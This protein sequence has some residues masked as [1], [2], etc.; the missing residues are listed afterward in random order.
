MNKANR[1]QQFTVR[2]SWSGR[3]SPDSGCAFASGIRL[4]LISPGCARHYS[5]AGMLA[6]LPRLQVSI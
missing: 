1:D 5:P 3:L 2:F 4:I 6:R